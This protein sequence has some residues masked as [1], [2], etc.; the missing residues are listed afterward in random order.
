MRRGIDRFK[1]QHI[2]SM[3]YALALLGLAEH[4][5]LGGLLGEVL[6]R[7]TDKFD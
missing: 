2:G 4:P 5:F 6:R 7:G 1:P 3:V